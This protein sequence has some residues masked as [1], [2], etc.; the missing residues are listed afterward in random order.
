MTFCF[1]TTGY[2]YV[3]LRKMSSAEAMLQRSA[4]GHSSFVLFCLGFVLLFPSSSF[5]SFFFPPFFLFLVYSFVRF[6]FCYSSLFLSECFHLLLGRLRLSFDQRLK[7]LGDREGATI[8]L[9]LFFS[10]QNCVA[11]LVEGCVLC[12][13]IV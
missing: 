13:E 2:E 9:R 12:H 1:F 6:C 11:L 3:F 8:N 10:V 4:T 7:N 5:F